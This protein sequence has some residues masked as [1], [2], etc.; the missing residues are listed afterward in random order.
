MKMIDVMLWLEPQTLKTDITFGRV[1]S[2]YHNKISSDNMLL[3]DFC[4]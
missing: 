2:E 3:D 1:I 4:I